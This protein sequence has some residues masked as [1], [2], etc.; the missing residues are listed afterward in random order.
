MRKRAQV[1]PD[2]D[3]T[4]ESGD[5]QFITALARGLSLLR[6]LANGETLGTTDLAKRSGLSNAVV[7]RLCYTLAN[8]NYME[9]LPEYGKYR[10]GDACLSLGYLYMASDLAS[11]VARPL[12]IELAE[13]ARVPVGIGRRQDL[14]IM[15][16]AMEGAQD[17]LSLRQ[18]AG[19]I[20]PIERTAMGN[21]YIAGLDDRR[22]QDI[23][24]ELKT[25]I[26]DMDIV[27]RQI[28]DN[29]ELYEKKGFCINDRTWLPHIRAVGVPLRMRD[30]GTVLAFNCGG[31]AD[32]LDLEFMTQEVG[33]RL[34]NLIR[35]VE[36]TLESQ[37][38]PSDIA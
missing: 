20:S 22:R 38:P 34:A 10:L 25:K 36:K 37:S 11:H 2:A 35:E 14:N 28:D 31:I 3:L 17:H 23:L 13:F 19:S 24:D 27:R 15:Q 6:F 7:S 5:R 16:I 1:L 9:Y 8:L 29:I 33:P 4:E 26:P 30:S 18:G 32:F 12:M 21:A